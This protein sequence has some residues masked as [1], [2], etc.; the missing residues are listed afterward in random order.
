MGEA[1]CDLARQHAHMSPDPVG[2]RLNGVIVMYRDENPPAVATALHLALVGAGVSEVSLERWETLVE[3]V[4]V[5]VGARSNV[6]IDELRARAES[7]E[8]EL[9]EAKKRLARRAESITPDMLKAF[10]NALVAMP[11]APL[12]I[13][14]FDEPETIDLS[15][16]IVAAFRAAKWPIT[17]AEKQIIWFPTTIGVHLEVA[18]L[19][20]PPCCSQIVEALKSLGVPNVRI[21]VPERK[22][23]AGSFRLFIGKKELQ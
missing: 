21:L 18:E 19:P 11:K 15:E 17:N 5:Y 2:R 22:P 3:D 14:V 13:A 6:P 4:E 10:A 16:R 8:L 7:A 20:G 23:E 1:G 12:E 9:T